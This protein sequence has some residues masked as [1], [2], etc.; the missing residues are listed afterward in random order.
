MVPR[1]AAATTAR[2]VKIARRTAA[3][4]AA[5]PPAGRAHGPSQPPDRRSGQSLRLARVLASAN[6]PLRLHDPTASHA[7]GLTPRADPR[8]ARSGSRDADSSN[9]ARRTSRR[10]A[11]AAVD[12]AA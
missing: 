12:R 9:A 2:R 3:A 6:A 5:T 8:T 1:A 11:V 4:R 10:Q 7:A